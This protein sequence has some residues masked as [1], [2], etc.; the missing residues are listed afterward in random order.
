MYFARLIQF[1][2]CGPMMSVNFAFVRVF[3]KEC[4]SDI[5]L[6]TTAAAAA[7][8]TTTTTSGVPVDICVVSVVVERR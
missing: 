1:I 5:I 8:T 7:N 2:L 3:N 6:I 4:H